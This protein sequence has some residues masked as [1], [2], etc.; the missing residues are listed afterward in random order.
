MKE[1]VV[2]FEEGMVNDYCELCVKAHAVHELIRCKDCMFSDGSY[3]KQRYH[4][5]CGIHCIKVP[6]DGFCSY[7]ERK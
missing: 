3:I 2:Q 7:A 4:K 6:D 1:Y 5:W